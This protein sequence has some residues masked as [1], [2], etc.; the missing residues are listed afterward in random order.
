MIPKTN[1]V[2]THRN[3]RPNRKLKIYTAPT[4]TKSRE[5]AYTHAL[6]RNNIDRQRVKIQRVRQAGSQ[7]AMVDSVWSYYIGYIDADGYKVR[8]VVIR[9]SLK[10]EE[11]IL[12][13]PA[14]SKRTE[15]KPTALIEGWP[16]LSFSVD[17][18]F[19]EGSIADRSCFLFL[20]QPQHHHATSQQQQ[21]QQE[22]HQPLQPLEPRCS[23]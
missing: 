3:R 12:Y 2:P 1:K 11:L 5:P 19:S 17:V 6:N 20:T 4:T 18:D 15:S 22:Q 10:A 13:I 9:T 14:L 21:Q 23:N 7:T 16:S 8:L